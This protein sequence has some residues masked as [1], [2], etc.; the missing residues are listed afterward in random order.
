[1]QWITQIVTDP[2]LA[3]VFAL[4]LTVIIVLALIANGQ[5]VKIRQLETSLLAKDVVIEDLREG[6]KFYRDLARR[7]AGKKL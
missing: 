7:T 5:K 4:C 6:K 1:M 2:L 3:F